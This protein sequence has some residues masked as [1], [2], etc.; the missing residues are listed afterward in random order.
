MKLKK[1]KAVRNLTDEA[2]I[3]MFL[4]AGWEEVKGKE[5]SED[6]KDFNK[7]LDKELASD[8]GEE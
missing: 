4:D 1:D 3:K 8:K 5:K 6:K 2:V 7:D